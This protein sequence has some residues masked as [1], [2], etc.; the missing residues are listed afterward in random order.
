MMEAGSNKQAY[1]TIPGHQSGVEFSLER[2]LILLAR[3]LGVVAFGVAAYAALVFSFFLCCGIDGSAYLHPGKS[4]FG[5]A[6]TVFLVWPIIG[7]LCVASEGAFET[8]ATA[9]IRIFRRARTA[10]R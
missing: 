2:G 6:V 1:S 9:I 10:Q 4:P 3:V 8:G 5:W 7:L